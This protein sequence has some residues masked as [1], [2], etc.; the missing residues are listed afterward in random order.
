MAK[1]YVVIPASAVYVRQE[2]Q[3]G[4]TMGDSQSQCH[5]S[6]P[7]ALLTALA[8][9]LTQEIPPMV[10]T[11]ATLDEAKEFADKFACGNA[12][13]FYIL[14]TIYKATPVYPK[15]ANLVVVE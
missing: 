6:S 12:D 11:F 3:G 5:A 2:H 13:S 4:Y 9:R 7:D 10:Q 8:R 15:A 1:L 14:E